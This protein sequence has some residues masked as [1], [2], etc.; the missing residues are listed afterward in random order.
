M[1]SARASPFA[2]DGTRIVVAQRA[3][4]PQHSLPTALLLRYGAML[5]DGSLLQQRQQQ[6][7]RQQQRQQQRQGEPATPVMVCEG[8]RRLSFVVSHP[9]ATRPVITN[10]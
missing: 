7:R 1:A 6:Q 2:T 3:R 10:H 5:S 9:R 8:G 4:V